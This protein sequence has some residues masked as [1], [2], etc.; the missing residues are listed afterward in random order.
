MLLLTRFFRTS[1]DACA[2][3]VEKGAVR[4]ICKDCASEL[5]KLEAGYTRAAAYPAYAVYRYDG[6]VRRLVKN[7][8]FGGHKWLSEFMADALAT[9]IWRMS[10]DKQVVS[11]TRDSNGNET[12]PL[13]RAGVHPDCICHVPLHKRR[14]RQRGFDQAQELAQKLSETT[15]IPYVCALKRIRHT[16]AQTKLR[17]RDR[18]KNMKGAFE[19]IVPIRGDVLLIDDVLTTGATTSECADVLMRAGA[20]SVHVLVFARALNGNEERGSTLRKR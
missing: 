3:G 9:G 18:L 4:G 5:R 16:K 14:R 1:T 6:K 19:S 8:K 11:G 17:Q 20:R 10:L 7:Y 2:A 13:R 15:S 12:S